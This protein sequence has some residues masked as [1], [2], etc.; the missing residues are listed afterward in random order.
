VLVTEKCKYF[1]QDRGHIEASF[2]VFIFK[3]YNQKLTET[4]QIQ[5]YSTVAT[6]LYRVF[7]AKHGLQPTANLF[8][9]SNCT[10]FMLTLFHAS[11]EVFRKY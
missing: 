8:S 11:A 7:K 9:C 2:G 10:T 6:T 3:N 1:M 4:H 5:R